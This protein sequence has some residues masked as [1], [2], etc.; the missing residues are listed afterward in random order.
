M[1]T[2]EKTRREAVETA[3]DI[4]GDLI[5]ERTFAMYVGPKG[6]GIFSPVG[7]EIQV[8]DGTLALLAKRHGATV[9]ELVEDGFISYTALIEGVYFHE[10]KREGQL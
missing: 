1:S 5:E 9:T 4:L 8:F 3:L 7:I 6:T 10:C 2:K